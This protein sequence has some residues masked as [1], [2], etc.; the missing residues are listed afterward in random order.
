VEIPYFQQSLL[1]VEAVERL[2]I[3]MP[4]I[5]LTVLE[6]DNL[7]PAGRLVRVD[8]MATMADPE[9]LLET[10]PVAVGVDLEVLVAAAVQ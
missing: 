6:E 3:A 7:A 8:F 10:T 2:T 5:L 1:M 9:R 4:E